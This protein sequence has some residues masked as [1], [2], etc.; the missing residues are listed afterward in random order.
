M[1]YREIAI[2]IV[3]WIGCMGSRLDAH[4]ISLTDVVINATEKSVQVQLRVLAEDLVL[5][6]NVSLAGSDR[7][8]QK[9]LIEAARKHREFVVDGLIL[10]NAK[11]ERLRARIE[12]LDTSNLDVKGVAQSETKLASVTYSISYAI[13]KSEF[14][15]I[16]QQFGGKKAVLPSLMDCMILQNDVLLEKPLQLMGGL[17]HTVRLDWANPPKRAKNW[18]E[19]RARK[20]TEFRKRLG[21]TSYSGLYS[22]IYITE[23]EVRHEILVPLLTLEA[24]T[25]LRRKNPEIVTVA[26]QVAAQRS[27]ERLM[28]DKA[29]IKIDRLSVRP[30]VSRVNFFGLD[31]NDFALNAGPRDV[32]VHNARVGIILSYSTK[33]MPN[34]ISLVWELFTEH[35][36]FMKSVVLA[37]DKDPTEQFFR[38]TERRFQWKRDPSV[39]QQVVSGTKRDKQRV[40]EKAARQVAST[41]LRNIYRAFDYREDEDTYDA[42]AISVQGSLLRKTYLQIRRSLLMAEQG[43]AKAKVNNVQVTRAKLVKESATEFTIDVTWEVTG[44]VE[45]WGHVH[46]RRNEYQARLVIRGAE[47]WKIEEL[48]LKNQKRIEFK[49]A[50]RGAKATK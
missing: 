3:A 10:R 39:T 12:K 16:Q 26:E 14:L 18:R 22:F 30:V 48:D 38:D 5:Y 40:T 23:H 2:A 15:S 19:L 35:A 8:S 6:Q 28:S 41:L 21:I 4:P 49:T 27:I 36:Q 25:P 7:Y 42:L 47:N 29:R 44:S 33:G 31:I 24:W 13:Q 45:H 1:R 50:L 9:S 11:G 20:E 37:F 17:K 46:T 43:G 34:E 32:S